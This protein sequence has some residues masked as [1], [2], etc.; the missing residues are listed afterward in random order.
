MVVG[1]L[2]L[3]RPWEKEPAGLGGPTL[4]RGVSN[5]AEDRFWLV[6]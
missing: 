3:G 5:V 4:V 6:C 2:K 1:M